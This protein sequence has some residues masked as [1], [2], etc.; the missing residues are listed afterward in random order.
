MQ[1]T[2]QA[3]T[4]LDIMLATLPDIA[5]VVEA[6]RLQDRNLADQLKRAAT[7]VALNLAEAD[8]VR[9]GHRR[10][11]LRTAMGSLLETRT[12]LKVGLAFRYVTDKTVDGID[13]RLD[14]VA[15]MTWRRIHP[16]R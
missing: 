7:S 13:H 9:G 8:G 11:R 4:A 12:A 1:D 10:N 6:I 16:R 15:A 2:Q 14:R 5:R 3:S